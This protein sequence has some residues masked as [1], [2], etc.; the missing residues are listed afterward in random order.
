MKQQPKYVGKSGLK[1]RALAAAVHDNIGLG[2]DNRFWHYRKGV[3]VSAP[4]IVEKR[5]VHALGDKFRPNH[6]KAVEP[7]IKHEF[8]RN[9]LPASPIAEGEWY[10]WVNTESV[11]YNWLTQEKEAHDPDF[12]SMVQLPFT[13]SAGSQCPKFDAWLDQV[14]PSNQQLVWEALGYMLMSGN[15][16]QVA[17]LL[18]G[19][20]GT[21]KSTFLRVLEHIL[22]K[23]NV[24]SQ[25]LRSLSSDR[26]SAAELF[27][28][29]ANIRSDIEASYMEDSSVFKQL[30]G[31]DMMS[32]QRKFQQPFDFRP[33]ATP[34]F[35]A[36]KVWRSED[37]TSGYFRRW[38]ILP[39]N[40]KLDRTQKFDEAALYAEAPGIFN[41]A[42]ANLRV[43]HARGE[44]NIVGA[45]RE[46]SEDFQKDS[47]NIRLWLA[48]DS[49]VDHD[50]GNESLVCDR[51]D[52]FR[53]Y[54]HWCGSDD[55]G[56]GI[57]AKK[58]NELYKSLEGLGYR[59][60]KVNGKRML[61]GIYATAPLNA[62]MY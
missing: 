10:P 54:K 32:A 60:K 62:V 46:A 59:Q 2:P 8:I 14:A 9:R 28:K 27:G 43:L 34:I 55:G 12:Q 44:F 51:A 33:W 5:C 52:V 31:G 22:G 41:K 13:F 58:A 30:T 21:G 56:G 45:A 25:S 36:N 17:F 24:A 16:L 49:N 35:S 26:F 53:A 48:E 37:D 11:M 15:P 6:V 61:I 20:G 18:L 7:V 19:P 40:E 47:D 4:E 38:V 3:W 23:H 50:A 39:F 29:I 1:V 57:N 42:M